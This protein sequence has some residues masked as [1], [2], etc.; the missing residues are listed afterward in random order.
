MGIR[1]GG[2]GNRGDEI[3]KERECSVGMGMGENGNGNGNGNDSIGVGWE[4]EPSF[5]HTSTESFLQVSEPVVED[6][7]SFLSDALEQV[8]LSD[9]AAVSSSVAIALSVMNAPPP[10]SSSSSSSTVNL[11]TPSSPDCK[12]F[13]IYAE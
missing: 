6:T 13:F 5:P 9:P 12:S 1:I 10:S 7:S 11:L 8:D 4:Q 3:N 2:N